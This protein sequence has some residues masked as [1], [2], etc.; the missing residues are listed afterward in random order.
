M[1]MGQP[2]KPEV[3]VSREQWGWAY[4]LPVRSET[5]APSV[6]GCCIGFKA[7]VER[8]LSAGDKAWLRLA[9]PVDESRISRS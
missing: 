1:W 9:G 3:R 8:V 5:N 4:R 6:S 7:V 2:L